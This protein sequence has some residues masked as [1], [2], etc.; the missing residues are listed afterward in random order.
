M[1]AVEGI[2]SRLIFPAE[3]RRLR[4]SCRDVPCSKP[5]SQGFPVDPPVLARLIMEATHSPRA[6]GSLVKVAAGNSRFQELHGS[7]P[8]VLFILNMQGVRTCVPKMM[9]SYVRLCILCVPG[10]DTKTGTPLLSNAAQP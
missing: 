6:Q 9:M 8:A 1:V 2:N 5:L 10:V 7:L 4:W 3:C